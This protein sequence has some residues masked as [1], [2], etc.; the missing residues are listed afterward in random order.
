MPQTSNSYHLVAEATNGN[1][2]Q[3]MMDLQLLKLSS[4]HNE[5]TKSIQ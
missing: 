5:K 4:I 2:E 3:P 1:Q